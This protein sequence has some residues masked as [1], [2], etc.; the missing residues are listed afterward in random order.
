MKMDRSFI[1]SVVMYSIIKNT[2][3]LFLITVVEC[4][5]RPA[6]TGKRKDKRTEL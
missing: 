4:L 5:C 1:H 6:Q 2:Q 3:A